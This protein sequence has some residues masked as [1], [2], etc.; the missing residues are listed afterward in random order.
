MTDPS[1]VIKGFENIGSSPKHEKLG[2]TSNSLEKILNKY[3]S[4]DESSKGCQSKKRLSKVIEE[5]V[6]SESSKSSGN[7]QGG[8]FK[9][10]PR[11]NQ[12]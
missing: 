1:I 12:N 9:I 5:P 11:K 2:D 10:T 3:N 7:L 4:L 8:F 6:Q